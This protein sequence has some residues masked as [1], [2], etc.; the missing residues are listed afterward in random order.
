MQQLQVQDRD[1]E[2][3]FIATSE[4][5]HKYNPYQTGDPTEAYS[6]THNDLSAQHQASSQAMDK[7]FK[8]ANTV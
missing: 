4:S 2:L 7:T 8:S 5:A 3:K 1:E 6:A